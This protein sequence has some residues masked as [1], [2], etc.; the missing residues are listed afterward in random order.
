MHEKIK[1]TNYIFP[2]LNEEKT[3]GHGEE[4]LLHDYQL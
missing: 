3:K 2:D 1:S 4:E